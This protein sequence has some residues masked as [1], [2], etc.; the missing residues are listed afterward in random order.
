[1]R[2][3]AVIGC[4]LAITNL[5]WGADMPIKVP[6]IKPVATPAFNW[7]GVYLGINGGYGSGSSNWAFPG[8]GCGG[9]CGNTG[10]FNINGPLAGGTLGANLQSGRFVS[11]I[12]TDGDWSNIKGATS[13]TNV[14]CGNCQTSNEWLATLRA[15]AGVAWDRVLLYATAGGAAG[16]I[17]SSVPAVPAFGLPAASSSSTEFGWTAGAGIEVAITEN[18]SAKVEYL[19]VDLKNGSFRCAVCAGGAGASVPVSFDASMVRSGLNLKFNSF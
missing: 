9:G 11:G 15:R 13:S 5:A 16:D 1:M 8:A 12:E 19:Y 4:L 10:N 18:V 6:P 7:S 14:T 3:F 17:K 2:V